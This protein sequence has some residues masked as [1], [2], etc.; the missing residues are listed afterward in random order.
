[1]GRLFLGK[2]VSGYIERGQDCLLMCRLEHALCLGPSEASSKVPQARVRASVGRC[3]ASPTTA[4]KS[5]EA[6]IENTWGG[7]EVQE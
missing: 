2:R 6:D 5:N 4:A 3:S 7:V 1:M